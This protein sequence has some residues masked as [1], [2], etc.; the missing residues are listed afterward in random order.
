MSTILQNQ[1]VGFSNS[2]SI[3]ISS[4]SNTYDIDFTNMT[5]GIYE[6][7]LTNFNPAG[8]W[9]GYV[10]WGGG[11]NAIVVLG[12]PATQTI[13]ASGNG[14]RLRFNN[15]SISVNYKVSLRYVVKNT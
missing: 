9:I 5:A 7:S 12:T 15:V 14:V 2:N 11:S 13:T 10:I 3:T 4:P 6:V 1:N 8:T